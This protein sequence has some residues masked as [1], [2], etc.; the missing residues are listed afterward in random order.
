MIIYGFFSIHSDLFSG[1][2]YWDRQYNYITA[3]TVQC[4]LSG[5]L[6]W[7]KYAARLGKTAQSTLSFKAQPDPF[8][9]GEV[10][11]QGKK[12]AATKHNGSSEITV[13]GKSFKFCK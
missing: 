1:N 6:V 4:G 8:V 13:V 2:I 12:V 11:L 3:C 5:Y 9:P 7:S 10:V